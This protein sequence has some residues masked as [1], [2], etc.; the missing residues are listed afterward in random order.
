MG[1]NDSSSASSSF[2]KPGWVSPASKLDQ[3]DKF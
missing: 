1:N 2:L 3:K